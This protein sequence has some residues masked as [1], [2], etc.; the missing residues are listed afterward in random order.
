MPE[1]VNLDEVIRQQASSYLY[2]PDD[3]YQDIK[4]VI[5]NRIKTQTIGDNS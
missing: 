2:M 3:V 5:Q 1:H 4:L